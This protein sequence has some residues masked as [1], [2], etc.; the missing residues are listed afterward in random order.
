MSATVE[1]DS[2]LGAEARVLV[3]PFASV[4]QQDLAGMPPQWVHEGNTANCNVYYDPGLQGEGP[5]IALGVL[6]TC[7]RDLA[8]IAG[9]FGGITPPGLPLEVMIGL[10]D[11]SGRGQGGAYHIG[12][13]GTQIYCDSRI[14]PQ[15]E[16]DYTRFVLAAE[17]VEVY[18]D[19]QSRG[20]DCGAS[21]G[22]ALSRVLAAELYPTQLN[23]FATAAAWLDSP[24]RPNWVDRTDPSDTHPVSIGCGALFI[25]FLERQ[26]GHPLNA[27]VGAGAPT[28]S[29]VY[30]GLEGDTRGWQRFSAQ[31][32]QAFPPGAP[33]GLTSD[34][35]YPLTGGQVRAQA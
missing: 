1:S 19:A 12:C 11:P 31:L 15:L 34:D 21:N 35:P 14:L 9:W 16:I 32:Q 2:P 25:N 8:T 30:A 29:A 22:E 17:L 28:L 27:I 4:D 5:L 24:D 20:W 10:I 18:S 3:N 26:L 23:G 6:K 33:S 7:E 13:A